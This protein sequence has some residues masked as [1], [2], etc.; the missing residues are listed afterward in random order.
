MTQRNVLPRQR[1][2]PAWRSPEQ[3]GQLRSSSLK[4]LKISRVGNIEQHIIWVWNSLTCFKPGFGCPKQTCW[5]A[6]H[7]KSLK[8]KTWENHAFLHALDSDIDHDNKVDVS[9][10]SVC[11]VR[12]STGKIG[13][14]E[15]QNSN[16][17]V[18]I[19]RKPKGE[20]C[21]VLLIHCI[22]WCWLRFST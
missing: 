11:G 16:M 6:A 13:K 10:L 8:K 21:P 1:A 22:F 2:L 14:S 20:P 4:T 9:H 17:I 18:S 3:T 7:E 15:H 5:C 12:K 19:Q